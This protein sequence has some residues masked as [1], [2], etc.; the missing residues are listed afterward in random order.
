MRPLYGFLV[1]IL[2]VAVTQSVLVV[3]MYKKL[4][5]FNKNQ[6][7]RIAKDGRGN[8]AVKS[9]SIEYIIKNVCNANINATETHDD[10]EHSSFMVL[11]T[12]KLGLS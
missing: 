2:V 12:N 6:V 1:G 5:D 11:R 9:K 10:F 3:K 4:E 8:G 7:H